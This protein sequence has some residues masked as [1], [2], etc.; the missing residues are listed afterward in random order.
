VKHIAALA[1]AG[2]LLATAAA[3]EPSPLPPGLDSNSANVVVISLVGSK[4]LKITRRFEQ[5]SEADSAYGPN[6]SARS[7]NESRTARSAEFAIALSKLK[8]SGRA[9]LDDAARPE[10]TAVQEVDRVSANSMAAGTDRSI[11]LE[12]A[13]VIRANVPNAT[14]G[15]VTRGKDRL[16]K[17]AQDLPDAASLKKVA[18]DL[19]LLAEISPA[20]RYI[21][22]T[23]Y[24]SQDWTGLSGAST[25]GIG[26][27]VNRGVNFVDI[28]EPEE[29]LDMLDTH[30]ASFIYLRTSVFDGKTFALLDSDT[31]TVNRKLTMARQNQGFDPWSGTSE[32]D[33]N[34][35]LK[36]LMTDT[37]RRIGKR[38]LGLDPNVDIGEIKLVQPAAEKT[39]A[40]PAPAGP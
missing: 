37:L 25:S 24:F 4:A 15:F 39:P 34:N 1:T 16:A 23:P 19:R 26:W 36:S 32:A 5:A 11:E 31:T 10:L 14:V 9:V 35:L 30:L 13:R 18:D 17:S 3:A 2:L 28:S 8:N 22:I 21:L 40:K 27:F 12:L 20:D 33:R 38:A 6:S 7:F 29:D